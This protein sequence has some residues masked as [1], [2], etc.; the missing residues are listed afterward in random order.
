MVDWQRSV[1]A[2]VVVWS[3]SPGFDVDVHEMFVSM[4]QK[5]ATDVLPL[6]MRSAW[7][8]VKAEFWP[9]S[10]RIIVFPTRAADVRDE[11]ALC[12]LIAAELLERWER[13]ADSGLPDDE[14]STEVSKL[15]AEYAR[16]LCKAAAGVFGEDAAIVIRCYDAEERE[17]FSEW[18]TSDRSAD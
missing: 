9:D 11:R 6:H 16:T 1:T 8:F 5:F 18:R 13:L 2:G 15:E 12:E 14:F 10:G 17:P 7:T 3:C 4:W